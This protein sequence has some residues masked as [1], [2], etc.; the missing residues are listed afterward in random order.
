[1]DKHI[2]TVVQNWELVAD[3]EDEGSG[4]TVVAVTAWLG[5][6][7]GATK[8]ELT[9]LQQWLEEIKSYLK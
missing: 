1:M 2:R 4:Y 9:Q 5:T 6:L 7:C 3:L 8:E